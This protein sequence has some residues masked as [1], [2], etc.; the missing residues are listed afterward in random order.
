MQRRSVTR[1]EAEAQQVGSTRIAPGLWRDRAGC[2]HV[3][4]PELLALV[5]LPD[6]PANREA[7]IRVVEE[8]W[9]QAHD[10]GRPIQIIRQD[11]Q[12]A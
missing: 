10:S 2:L 5:D 4:V 7:V 8:T 11:V 6:T 9:G 3:S 1:A 12:D